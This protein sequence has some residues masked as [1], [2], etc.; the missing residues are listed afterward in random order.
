MFMHTFLFVFIAE[1]ADKTQFMIMALTNRYKLKTILVG[2][3]LGVFIISAFSVMCGDLIGDLVP[4]WVVKVC[5]AILFLFFGLLTLLKKEEEHQ[6]NSSSYRFP[7]ISI[8]G[9]FLLA[10]LGD[11]TQLATVALAAD[12]TNMQLQIFC[13]AS[14]GLIMANVIGI[15]AGKFLF[16]HISDNAIRVVSSFIFLF[17]GSITIFELLPYNPMIIFSYS[18]IIILIAYFSYQHSLR[19]NS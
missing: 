6:H 3:S 11:K 12:H 9:T 7:I 19:H 16:S 10:E 15:F 2:M 5:G 4:I 18:I 1:M 17:F 8:A 14:L 13:G